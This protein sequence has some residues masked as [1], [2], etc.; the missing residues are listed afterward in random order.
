MK[1]ENKITQADVLQHTVTTTYKGAGISKTYSHVFGINGTTYEKTTDGMV[2]FH[3]HE[4]Y[5]AVIL[6]ANYATKKE[7]VKIVVEHFNDKINKRQ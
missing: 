5:Q 3:S 2:L 1:T 4:T 6:D 7:F